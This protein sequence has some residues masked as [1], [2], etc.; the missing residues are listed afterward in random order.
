MICYSPNGCIFIKKTESCFHPQSN[1][2]HPQPQLSKPQKRRSSP[3]MPMGPFCCHDTVAASHPI[4]RNTSR[5][6]AHTRA[7]LSMPRAG[8][9]ALIRSSS[10]W[11]AAARRKM[12]KLRAALC[13]ALISEFLFSLENIIVAASSATTNSCMPFALT[14][15]CAGGDFRPPT[16]HGADQC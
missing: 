12:P 8:G 9:E 3:E 11:W 2:N 15:T 16:G 4:G 13:D 10:G 5:P 14:C 1:H 6:N 7:L